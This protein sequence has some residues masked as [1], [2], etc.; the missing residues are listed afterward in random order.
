MLDAVTGGE[1]AA[2]TVI[3]PE[4][5]ELMAVLSVPS[6]S[7]YI[8]IVESPD[9]LN[10]ECIQGETDEEAKANHILIAASRKIAEDAIA[11]HEQLRWRKVE[12]DNPF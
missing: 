7:V 2:T 10:G 11:L 8:E 9:A 12:D 6:P 3:M 5:K 1:W 4:G